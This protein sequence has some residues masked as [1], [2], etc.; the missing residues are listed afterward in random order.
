MDIESWLKNCLD[1]LESR[2]T[3]APTK[4]VTSLKGKKKALTPVLPSLEG[5]NPICA[6]EV[7]EYGSKKGWVKAVET[8]TI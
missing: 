6:G 4:A 7:V 3:P 1:E 5:L 8:R 2:T